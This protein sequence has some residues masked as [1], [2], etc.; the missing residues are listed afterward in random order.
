MY[1]WSTDTK[2]LKKNAKQYT[3]WRLEQLINYGLRDEKI[4]GKELRQNFSSLN[5][6]PDKKTFLKFILYGKKPTVS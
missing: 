6:D 2:R 3:I 4:N 1:N 5:I